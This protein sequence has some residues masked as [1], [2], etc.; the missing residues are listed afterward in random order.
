MTEDLKTLLR[1][2]LEETTNIDSAVKALEGELAMAEETT[3]G[4]HNDIDKLETKLE[5]RFPDPEFIAASIHDF[6]WR[7]GYAPDGLPWKCAP[8]AW[9]RALRMAAMELYGG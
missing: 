5:A 7:E 9:Q 8:S 2:A 1:K 3:A 4:L 6:L